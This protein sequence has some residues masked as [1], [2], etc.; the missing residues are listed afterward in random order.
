[1]GH[2][3]A[4]LALH[5]LTADRVAKRR[6]FTFIEVMVVVVIIGILAA[7]VVPRFANAQSDAKLAAMKATL[8]DMRGAM[9]NFYANTIITGTPAYPTQAQLE[10]LFTG[11]VPRN[12]INGKAGVELVTD[13][14]DADKRTVSGTSAGWRYYYD[15]SSNPPV[16]I[17]YANDA[18]Y[19]FDP[20][21]GA[22]QYVNEY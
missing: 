4:M 9:A 10:A 6:A 5:S 16:G 7:I 3:V 8:G 11:G 1:M 22:K 21:T 15:N 17:L 12:P 20:S 14:D 19:L 18:S 2:G 13:P